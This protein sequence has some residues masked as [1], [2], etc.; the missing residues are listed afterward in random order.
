MHN[1]LFFLMIIFT[2]YFPIFSLNN[3]QYNYQYMFQDYSR[4]IRYKGSRDLSFEFSWNG[5]VIRTTTTSISDPHYMWNLRIFWFPEE[6][7]S[8]FRDHCT[9]REFEIDLYQPRAI[10]FKEIY[11]NV[12]GTQSVAIPP[13]GQGLGFMTSSIEELV[14][15]AAKAYP[16]YKHQYG[17]QWLRIQ[18]PK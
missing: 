16:Q 15:M 13:R 3:D 12:D 8:F 5:L 6:Q 7:E 4:V 11:Q 10:L 18:R 1:P 9:A 17:R 2:P 14:E